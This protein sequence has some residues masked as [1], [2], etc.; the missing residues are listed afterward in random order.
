M[1]MI[2]AYCHIL[3]SR[4]QKAFDKVLSRRDPNLNT[5]KYAQ[6]VP[7]LT[8]LEARFRLMDRFPG[9]M[10]V[11]TVAAPSIT[12]VAEPGEAVDLARLAN[13]ELAELVHRHPH[14]FAAGIACLPL[15][16]PD[17][18]FEEARRA[19]E[20]LRLRGVEVF[21]DIGGKPLDHESFMPL[22]EM[23]EAYN[24]PIL[25]HPQK[26]MNIP[27][28][29]GEEI[30]EYRIWTKLGWPM[31]TAMAMTRLVY[32]RV[33][34]RHP[35]LKFMTHHCGGVIPFVAG[36]LEW[37]DDFNEMCMGHRDIFLKHNALHDYRLFYYDTAVNGNTS[38][39]ECGRAFCG[40]DHLVFGT[41]M[42]FDNQGGYRLVRETIASVERMRLEPEEKEK[43]F[44][45]NVIDLMRLPLGTL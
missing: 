1:L 19:V 30:S 9:Y 34:E 44:Q 7:L 18:A 28:Y 32:G 35:G 13:D 22:Y 24:L 15:N 11:L 14:R 2:D 21:S 31:A 38:A 20:D 40:I 26:E 25:I 36:R 27:D 16:D 4:Y 41:D 43:V 8:D 3:P 33:L 29:D 23:M 17:A 39:L 45:K 6:S 37:S 42:P 10:Q 12:K 5:S